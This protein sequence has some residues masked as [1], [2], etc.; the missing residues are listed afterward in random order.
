MKAKNQDSVAKKP[1]SPVKHISNLLSKN[2][3]NSDFSKIIRYAVMIIVWI[4]KAKKT[5]VSAL[6]KL[7]EK[8]SSV[9]AAALK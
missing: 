9:S 6:S 8:F 2:F 4:T 1:A 3:L 5:V 7:D